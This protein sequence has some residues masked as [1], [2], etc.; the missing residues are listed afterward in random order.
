MIRR[1]NQS[2]N[3]SRLVVWVTLIGLIVL[4][5]L[6][7]FYLIS[8][9]FINWGDVWIEVFDNPI[10][11]DENW[12]QILKVLFFSFRLSL[13]AVAFDL[14]FGVPLAYVLARKQFPGKGLLEDIITLPLVIPTSGF[15]F[16]TLITWTSVAGIGGFLGMNT[17]VV[18]L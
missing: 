1:I 12:R 4:V 10:I 15:G 3:P 14:I 11:G 7:T 2:I 9:V 18:S 16:A 17:G 5:L 6:P 8:Y 13:S